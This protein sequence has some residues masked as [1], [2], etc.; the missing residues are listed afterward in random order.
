[1]EKA[2]EPSGLRQ[3][4]FS[5]TAEELTALNRYAAD[6]AQRHA[7]AGEDPPSGMRIVF[8]FTPFGRSVTA[9]FDGAVNGFEVCSDWPRSEPGE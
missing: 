6:R 4:D 9:Y 5:L 7:Q 8:D 1:M 2:D 3:Q